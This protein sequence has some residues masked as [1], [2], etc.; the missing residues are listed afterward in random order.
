M[1]FSQSPA[2]PDP[3]IFWDARVP[4][5]CRSPTHLGPR[6]SRARNQLRRHGKARGQGGRRGAQRLVEPLSGWGATA[7][8]MWSRVWSQSSGLV[9]GGEVLRSRRV[10]LFMCIDVF[11][12]V[13]L[14]FSV[15][16]QT[17]SREIRNGLY[18]FAGCG[19]TF[20]EGRGQTKRLVGAAA[21]GGRTSLSFAGRADPTPP[22]CGIHHTLSR[23]SDSFQVLPVLPPRSNSRRWAASGRR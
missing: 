23:R 2:C 20:R 10:G 16:T 22:R 4:D 1:P 18:G 6:P 13:G 5:P 19:T 9:D 7:P 21:S 11:I 3:S 14:T 8:N 17:H 15:D 12:V